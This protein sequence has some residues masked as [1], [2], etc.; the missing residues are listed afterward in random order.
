MSLSPRRRHCW[1]LHWPRRKACRRGPRNTL[2]TDKVCLSTS[3]VSLRRRH[4]T[5]SCAC[6]SSHLSPLVINS[7]SSSS[8]SIWYAGLTPTGQ[9]LTTMQKVFYPSAGVKECTVALS[10][11]A[12]FLY[13]IIRLLL[14]NGVKSDILAKIY[15]VKPSVV[16]SD[17]DLST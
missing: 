5:A 6:L 17:V 8:S 7:S 15:T 1:S 4:A 16:C 3:R 13:F 12:L 2:Q 14:Q 11:S 10:F 9:H